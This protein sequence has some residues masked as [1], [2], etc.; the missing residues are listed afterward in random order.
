MC[1]GL[2]APSGVA[3]S[4]PTPDLFWEMGGGP[5]KD[6]ED[7]GDERKERKRETSD[8]DPVS[9]VFSDETPVFK[10][11]EVGEYEGGGHSRLEQGVQSIDVLQTRLI[12]SDQMVMRS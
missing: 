3:S 5:G 10:G 4:R 6:S 11:E 9:M 8:A 2:I 1:S 12:Q 7:I